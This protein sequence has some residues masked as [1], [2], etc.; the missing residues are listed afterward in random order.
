MGWSGLT[1]AAALAAGVPGAAPVDWQ[2]WSPPAF[3]RAARERRLVLLDL[4]AGWCH[5]CHVMDETTYRDQDVR[6]LLAAH[7]VAIRVDQDSRPDLASRYEDYGWPATVIFD[8]AGGEL[9]RFRGY[10]PPPRM[11]ALLQSV[12][13]DPTPGPSVTRAP[14]VP[15]APP[16]AMTDALRRELER[17]HVERYDDEHGGWG[18]V[19]KYLDPDSVEYALA[20]ARA[21]DARAAHMARETLERQLQLFDPVWGGVYQYSDGGVWSNPHFEK[22][23]GFQAGALRAY[24]AAWALWRDPAHLRAAREVHRYLRAF[25]RAP[26]GAFYASQDADVV[27]GQHAA[28][29]FALPDAER[30]A[31]GLPRVDRSLYTRENGW[32]VEA[33]AE[34]YRA[35]GDEQALQDAVTAARWLLAHRGRR[36]GG[37]AHGEDDRGG[38]FLADTVA[39]G[40]GFLALFEATGRREWL[41][42]ASAAAAFIDRTFRR[43]G[44]G[45]YLTAAQGVREPRP[46]RDE[47][48]AVG[49][50]A[51][52]LHRHTGRA[53]EAAMAAQA[54]GYLAQPQVAR[55]FSTAGVLLLLDEMPRRRAHAGAGL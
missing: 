40:R 26:E 41:D 12:V 46:N 36:E 13:E 32:A 39:A 14:A 30:R 16:A 27:P 5:W 52:R 18:F 4:G 50:F 28:G 51:A 25:L 20:R 29:Y 45:G 42:H 31:R 37:F 23:M 22:I 7:Y 44:V 3:E 11:R 48:V 17:L 10:I 43:Q 54:L 21:G 34:L 2:E 38:P 8:S 53:A 33:L 9:V 6:R 35:A 49:R 55:R 1:L 19:H 24:A 15:P 47:N